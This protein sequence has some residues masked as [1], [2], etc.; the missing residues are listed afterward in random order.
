VVYEDEAIDMWGLETTVCKEASLTTEHVYAGTKAVDQSWNRYVEGCEFAGIGI[1][2]DG[3]AG[4]DLSGL[5]DY[6]AF[7]FYVRAKEEKMYGLPIVLTLE[8]YSGGMGF[9]YTGNKYFERTLIDTSWQKVTVPLSAFDLET[10]NLDVTNI[11]QLQL[12]L[13]QSGHI[14]L[15]EISLV[16]Y[17]PQ[18]VEPWMVD[19]KPKDALK[20][21][22]IIYDEGFIHN[23]GWG[24]MENECHRV[25][26]SSSKS[27][28]G[29]QS[30][31][32]TWDYTRE[33]CAVKTFGVSWNKWFPV[34]MSGV[35][36]EYA[37]SFQVASSEETISAIPIRVG[38]ED[39]DRRF[40]SVELQAK[41]AKADAF[42]PEWVEVMIPLSE[43]QGEMDASNIKQVLF[44]MDGKGEV[45]IDALKLIRLN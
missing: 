43:L 23:N 19:E 31:H 42:G 2:W 3:Y 16:F 15:D 30:L 25:E 4:K 21:P 27:F 24:L 9:A 37:L 5:M 32:A 38:L 26:F 14:Y 13:Q 44:K 7:E 35:L 6:A 18:E 36:P 20:T 22:V 28:S 11:K 10:E 41:Y 1:G 34:D 45:Y 39:Y 17:T 29:K 8:D 33:D 12:E 40:A